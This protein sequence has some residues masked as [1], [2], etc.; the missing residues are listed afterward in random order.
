MGIV[1]D[2]QRS[3]I[4]IKDP[5]FPHDAMDAMHNQVG[6]DMHSFMIAFGVAF[7]ADP[8][9]G[10]GG[11]PA[12][13]DLWRIGIV[14]N[15]MYQMLNFEYEN[16]N[17]FTVEF[18]TPAVDI[19]DGTFSKPFYADPVFGRTRR[20][21]RPV[22]DIWFT[23][24]GYGELLSPISANGVATN[25]KPDSLDMWDEP[26]TGVKMRLNDGS[27]I[28]RIE[29]VVSFQTWLVAKTGGNI[30]VLAHAPPFSLAFW[31]DTLPST[32]STRDLSFFTP[33]FKSGFFA[34]KG[35]W[36]AKTVSRTA[37]GSPIVQPALGNGGKTPVL[38]GQ[39]AGERAVAWIKSKGIYP[40]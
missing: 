27:L 23:S 22:S 11:A 6:F 38:S 3:D 28:T 31:I 12:D 24:Q 10:V 35:I 26:S 18:K 14:Q 19:V 34:Q 9:K 20:N 8:K 17:K 39:S 36:S 2:L 25:N 16:N 7:D 21:T 30:Q 4:T 40:A 1:V 33:K 5:L 15:V 37:S 13:A 29:K 32:S